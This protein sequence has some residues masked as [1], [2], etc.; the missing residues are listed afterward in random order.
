MNKT[1]LAGRICSIPK[2]RLLQLEGKTISVCNFTLG[3]ADGV[4]DI[5]SDEDYYSQDNV[6][7]FECVAFEGTAKMINENFIKGS[8]ILC[9][10][11][12]KN[13]FFSDAN[14]T[15]HFTQVFVLESAEFGDTEA[16][17][18]KYSGDK[19]PS[20]LSIVSD[21]N[22]VYSLFKTACNN[23]YLC[24]DEDDYYKIAMSNS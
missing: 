14:F 23:G 13:H 17:F 24:I 16:V 21:L 5:P 9:T 8:K 12:M 20:E 10:G 22:R 1:I 6:D 3:V 11:K 2:I 7:F 15:N 18:G 19:K 4:F